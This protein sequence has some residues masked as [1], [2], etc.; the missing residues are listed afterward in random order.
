MKYDENKRGQV[1][2]LPPQIKKKNYIEFEPI[3]RTQISR[4][5]FQIQ[6]QT[7]WG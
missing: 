1:Y 4:I 5:L 7:F 6:G 3:Y 2:M